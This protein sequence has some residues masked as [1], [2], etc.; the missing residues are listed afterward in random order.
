M[1]LEL[2][3]G[4]NRKGTLL[5]CLES[6]LLSPTNEIIFETINYLNTLVEPVVVKLSF[7]SFALFM[8]F[9]P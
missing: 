8:L 1:Q 5:N 4:E 3:K 2:V 6:L 9:F 7:G